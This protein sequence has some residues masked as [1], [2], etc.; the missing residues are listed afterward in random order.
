LDGV[1]MQ[2]MERREENKSGFLEQA[3]SMVYAS[4]LYENPLFFVYK[5]GAKLLD[6]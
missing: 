3:S 5:G 1:K 2:V 6:E 4:V